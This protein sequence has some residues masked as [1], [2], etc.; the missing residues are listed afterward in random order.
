MVAEPSAVNSRHRRPKGRYPKPQNG[1]TPKCR[2]R[3]TMYLEADEVDA[4][5]RI[6][7]NP[8]ASAAA[9]YRIV[10]QS[11]ILGFKLPNYRT[12]AAQNPKAENEKGRQRKLSRIRRLRIDRQAGRTIRK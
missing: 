2:K 1:A 12:N 4:I 8:I 5:I 3:I 11:I 7:S 10:Q 6:A 9:I